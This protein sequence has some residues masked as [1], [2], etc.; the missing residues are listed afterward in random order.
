MNWEFNEAA[1]LEYQEAAE[2]YRDRSLQVAERFIIEV[3]T[4]ILAICADPE[5]YQPVGDGVR[6]YR[7]K[8]FPF[9]IYYLPGSDSLIIYAVMHERRR[10]DYWLGRL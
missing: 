7:L 5:R 3:E 8:R 4:A 9:R 10:P 2:W 1:L 6:V